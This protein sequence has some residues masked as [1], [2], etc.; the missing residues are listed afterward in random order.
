MNKIYIILVITLLLPRYA[1][2]Y[3]CPLEKAYLNE[4][5]FSKFQDA[6][7]VGV[8]RPYKIEHYEKEDEYS[9]YNLIYSTVKKSWKSD[10]FREIVI[11]D[12]RS[13]ISGYLPLKKNSEYLVYGY[14]PDD[15]GYY[16][17]YTC[18]I[19]AFDDIAREHKSIL[20][21]IESKRI[22]VS[23]HYEVF[24]RID[25]FI[26]HY[27]ISDIEVQTLNNV[28]RVSIYLE[29]GVEDWV[30][31]SIVRF[32]KSEAKSLDIANVGKIEVAKVNEK[33]TINWLHPKAGEI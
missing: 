32:I 27:N 4:I 33:T 26:S 16:Q 17:V 23:K 2:A 5:I 6:D 28:I 3:S 31:K 18:E 12:V 20:D 29:E 22:K 25:E 21:R 11:K 14:G 1:L 15:S 9:S 13:M 24:V 7:V 10:N 8:L 30:A 19:E